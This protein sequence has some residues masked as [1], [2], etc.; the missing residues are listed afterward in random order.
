MVWVYKTL[1]TILHL[2]IA[3]VP[4]TGVPSVTGCPVSE[5]TILG[6]WLPVHPVTKDIHLPDGASGGQIHA[7]AHRMHHPVTKCPWLSD[8]Q[9]IRWP[10]LTR[11][12]ANGNRGNYILYWR[13]K[14]LK[15]SERARNE[16][17]N[18]ATQGFLLVWM[19]VSRPTIILFCSLCKVRI[20]MGEIIMT[21]RSVGLCSE[22]LMTLSYYILLE[23]NKKASVSHWDWTSIL[24]S[25]SRL[26][27]PKPGPNIIKHISA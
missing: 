26:L 21:Y 18:S 24:P 23:F 17:F 20:V 7:L 16:L 6:F 13:L 14:L 22:L 25:V 8:F 12:P 19:L 1:K 3:K 10:N 15:L 5:S 9:T 4:K 2:D 27:F 11:L